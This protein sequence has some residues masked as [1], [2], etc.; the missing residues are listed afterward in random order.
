MGKLGNNNQTLIRHDF[1][2]ALYRAMLSEFTIPEVIEFFQKVPL[3]IQGRTYPLYGVFELLWKEK[4]KIPTCFDCET[5]NELEPFVTA[6]GRNID[7]VMKK[8]LWLNS[9]T[10][11]MPGKVLLSWFYP[12]IESLFS[13]L[14]ARDIVFALISLHNENWLPGAIHRRVKKWEDGQWVKS[15]MAFFT[16]QT[17]EEYIDWDFETIG[18]PQV[19]AAPAM[20]GLPPFEKLAMLA[21]T[22]PPERVVWRK[23]D[24]PGWDGD[25]LRLG[26]EVFGKRTGFG[27]FCHRLEIDLSKYAPP[28]LQVVEMTRN[29]FCPVRTRVAL[30]Q[31]CVYGAP[32]FLHTVEHRKLKNLK[33]D[34][35]GTIV[36]DLVREEEF[37]DDALEAKHRALLASLASEFKYRY[38]AAEESLTLNESHFIKGIPAKILRF[39]LE[40]YLNDGKCEFEYRELK[41]LFEISLGQKNSNFELRFYRLV[42]KLEGE[43]G[44][45]RIEKTGRGKFRLVVSGHLQLENLA[46]RHA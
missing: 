5:D 32:L 11:V 25:I 43:S 37:Q 46:A 12:K 16:D 22:R 17:F 8:V 18:G 4:A 35:L 23:E 36:S 40:A 27:D 34:V 29:Y 28:D 42:E 31:G 15:I 1:K 10:S 9:N 44:G 26:N 3:V 13:S 21:D 2:R 38:F 45:L 39:L 20:V 41:R 33:K 24:A 30:H 7:R 6:K 14:D 19:L